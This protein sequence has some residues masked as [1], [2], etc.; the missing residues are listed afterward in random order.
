MESSRSHIRQLQSHKM[1]RGSTSILKDGHVSFKSSTLAYLRSNATG[2]GTLAL[3]LTLALIYHAYIIQKR[4]R[5]HDVSCISFGPVDGV[6]II[7]NAV[8]MKKFGFGLKSKNPG[9]GPVG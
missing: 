6:D 5:L 2:Q 9:Y 4:R 1:L 8:T 3:R 7:H